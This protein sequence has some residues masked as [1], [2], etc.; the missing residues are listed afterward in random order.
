MSTSQRKATLFDE[1]VEDVFMKN[2]SKNSR[3]VTTRKTLEGYFNIL[4]AS[5][6]PICCK[7]YF[8]LH[9]HYIFLKENQNSDEK[10]YMDI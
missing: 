6:N 1:D 4:S 2:L 7:Y 10:V 9:D 3:P 5:D 8:E